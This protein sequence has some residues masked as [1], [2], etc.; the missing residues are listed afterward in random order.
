MC[1]FFTAFSAPASTNVCPRR[2]ACSRRATCSARSAL[3]SASIARIFSFACSARPWHRYRGGFPLTNRRT[4]RRSKVQYA[5]ASGFMSLWVWVFVVE[6]LCSAYFCTSIFARGSFA[7][8]LMFLCIDNC[9]HPLSLS[10]HECECFSQRKGNQLSAFRACAAASGAHCPA[11][12]G[13][14]RV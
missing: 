13:T 8:M 9:H 14:A 1:L 4:R 10:M 3:P 11:T 6:A 5:R 7:S 12:A 2:P